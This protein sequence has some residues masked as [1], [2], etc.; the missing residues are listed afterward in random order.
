MATLAAPH[1]KPAL[2]GD[3]G[4]FLY[5]SIAM[6]LT[7]FAGFGLQLGMGRSSFASPA[8]VHA[9][10]IVFMGW[11]VLYLAQNVFVATG[12]IGLHKRLGWIGAGW[13]VAMVVLGT[14]VT[15]RL[16]QAGQAPFFFTPLMFLVMDPLSVITFAG[17]SAAAIVYRRQTQWHR[18]LHY[19]GMSVLLG[20]AIGRLIPMPLLIPYAY[21]AV[22]LGVLIFPAIGI[23]ADLHRTG[24]V[25]PA[26]WW[27]LGTIVGSTL[28]VEA[29]VHTP[30]G[31]VVYR[32]VTAE[33]PG[34][35]KAPRAYPPWPGAPLIKQ[36]GASI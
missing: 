28:L 22:F 14:A 3:D 32:G 11:V 31:D 27:G 16:V 5:T 35:T 12:S 29:I 9:H 4:F 23:I 17:L 6:A 20:P 30:V 2:R 15:I 21:E 33:T 26:W 24:R 1:L 36:A 19:C 7:I 25:H 8:I 34:A 10:A 18:R 13:M